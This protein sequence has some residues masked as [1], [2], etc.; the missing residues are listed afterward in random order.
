MQ[1]PRS[2]LFILT[3]V[4]VGGCNDTNNTKT[5]STAGAATAG[6]ATAGSVGSP[7]VTA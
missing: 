5:N 3:A 2:S 7:G 6:A 1:L 4:L